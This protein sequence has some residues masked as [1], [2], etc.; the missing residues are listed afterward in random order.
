MSLHHRLRCAAVGVSLGLGGCNPQPSKAV[1]LAIPGP[2]ILGVN[3]LY[4]NCAVPP[5]PPRPESVAA[6]VVVRRA[7]IPVSDLITAMENG[8]PE[9]AY[10]PLELLVQRRL[11]SLGRLLADPKSGLSAEEVE[12]LKALD[13]AELLRRAR[14]S[15][16]L[17]YRSRAVAELG[18][19]NT[20]E[21]RTALEAV[22]LDPESP[23][24]RIAVLALAA[25]P[26]TDPIPEQ[27]V[28]AAKSPAAKA[29]P[30][31]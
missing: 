5:R 31:P 7:V 24:Q 26:E 1:D 12:V 20:P 4:E 14:R 16:E 8:P 6:N 23:L 29:P 30:S 17:G 27:R 19:A 25:D 13:A 2:L 10:A 9:S 22:A 3:P 18:R 15:V 21:A 28:P 11:E